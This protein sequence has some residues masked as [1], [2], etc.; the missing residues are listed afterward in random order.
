MSGHHDSTKGD[1]AACWWRHIANM[2]PGLFTF[3]TKQ[4]G[5][6]VYWPIAVCTMSQ[7]QSN[8][9]TPI[10]LAEDTRLFRL[11]GCMLCGSHT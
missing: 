4:N 3:L 8:L 10:L 1:N 11:G 5:I 9:Q 2:H 6:D 7:M